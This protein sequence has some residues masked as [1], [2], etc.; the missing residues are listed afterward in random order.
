MIRLIKGY[1]DCTELDKVILNTHK[2]DLDL[3]ILCFSSFKS[4]LI[5]C[6]PEW[7]K[8]DVDQNLQVHILD[9]YRK[10]KTVSLLSLFNYRA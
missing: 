2:S 5:G 10:S 6:I 4:V 8:E 7:V 3:V 9:I 1:F